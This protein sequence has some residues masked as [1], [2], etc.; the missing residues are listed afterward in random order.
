LILDAASTA[1]AAASLSK[2][3]DQPQFAHLLHFASRRALNSHH[4][5]EP[6]VIDSHKLRNAFSLEQEGSGDRWA[7][8]AGA[9]FSSPTRRQNSLT[10]LFGLAC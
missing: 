4:A 3:F 6:V 5:G 9:R 10:E 8:K 1:S 7:W 2:P